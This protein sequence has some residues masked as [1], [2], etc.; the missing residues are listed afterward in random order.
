MTEAEKA[1]AL[2]EMINA[3]SKSGVAAFGIMDYWTFDGYWALRDY[4][5]STGKTL[6]QAIFPGME[7][8]IEAPVDYRLNIHVILS[9][10]L[11]KQQL[12][13]FKGA[14]RLCIGK[15][16]RPLSDESLIEYARTL[17]ESVATKYEFSA[18]DLEVEDNLL[19]LGSKTA[20][21]TRE[22]LRDAQR[23]V[24]NKSCLI[25]L[26]Y[27]TSDGLEG[28][29]WAKHPYDD[30]VFMQS[31]HIFE[32]R[33][34]ANVDLFLNRETDK[35]K[36]FIA[37]FLK[38]MGGRPK[39]AISGSDAHKI[40][41]YGVFPSNRMTW[42]KADPTF[43]GLL[44]VVIEP[45]ERSFIGEIPAKLALVEEKS[46]K[47]ITTIRI[48]R[49]SSAT[50]KEVWFDNTIPINPGLIAIIGNK[51]K[52]KS[53]LTDTIGL[54][55]NTKQHGHFTFLSDKNFRQLKE[56]KAKHF[57]ATLIWAGGPPTTKGLDERVDEQKP[58]LVKYI[59]QNFLETICTQLG[60]IEETEFDREL[61]KVIFSHVPPGAR[62]G[63]ASLDDLIQYKTT[64]ASDKLQ[65]L[66]QE[67]Q[68]INEEIVSLEER[69]QPEHRQSIEN[70]LKLKNQELDAH[71]EA[72][73][74][75]VQEPTNDPQKQEEIAR[76][77]RLLD[78][79]KR[80][81][82]GYEDLIKA[83]AAAQA[84]HIQLIAIV[85]KLVPR[86]EN[87]ERQIQSFMVASEAEFASIGLTI[88]DV[89]KISIDKQPLV[90]KRQAFTALMQEAQA[91]QDPS[92]SGSPAQKELAAQKE[93][94][95]LQ[96]KLDEPNKR[97]QAYLEALKA[98]EEQRES[99]IGGEGTPGTIKFYE[100]Q[101]SDLDALP[102]QLLQAKS[103]RLAK[104]KELH[105]VIRQLAETY[106]DLYAPVNQFIE[107]RPLAKEKFHL[108]FEVGVV[109]TGF[110]NSLF[111]FISQGVTGTF[112]GVEEGHKRL[113]EILTKQDFNTE[114][115]IEVFLTEI[116]DALEND[117]R[118]GGGPVRISAQMR[119]RKTPLEL[120]DFV[121]GLD[122]LKPRYALRMGEKELHQLSP[123]ERGTLL[124]VFYLLVDKDDIPLV[125]DQPE[126]NL[127][128]QTVYDLLVPCIKEAK[129][130]RQIFIVT[131]NPNLAVVCDAEQIIWA[132]L[133]KKN[134]Y[135]MNYVSGA[136]ESQILNKA[137]VDIL[138]G[139]MPAFDNRDSKYF[140]QP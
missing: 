135:V 87:L 101:L 12:N 104:A 130:R 90:N 46:T 65:I 74:E 111:D 45:V 131:H 72:K 56:N 39:P 60:G 42:I 126:E 37:N 127:D 63:R 78:D 99:I 105:A 52:G 47:Y 120:F 68:K 91:Q 58:E 32:T 96:T 7:L 80:N 16:D 5:A 26:P 69:S 137:T 133:D 70:L 77:A 119:T 53:A 30:S 3:V 138:E 84:K 6:D 81:L 2:E 108:N 20:K 43:E 140:R 15:G 97:Y 41:D 83:A 124:L 112:C 27:D 55:A 93:I 92:Q 122:Y 40:S 34:P 98:W 102:A 22:S 62:L 8:R 61:K 136:I 33:D 64:E 106:R 114:Q 88:Q 36:H 18:A 75:V 129:Q 123:G 4:L 94:E 86:V 82:A 66:K 19:R 44:Q 100:K 29:D 50:L 107:S 57:Q 67:L 109:D 134:N 25:I 89:V 48:E 24:P 139:T 59:P 28:L 54:L 51:G 79:I 128:N 13:D 132:D 118:P 73:P 31:A 71:E 121:F 125:I 113:K 23:Q 115:G 49:K 85:D 10:S 1:A 110:E 103:N 116:T 9:D 35:N 117:K 38:T 14:L 76:V 21:V 17:D 95:D 11:S